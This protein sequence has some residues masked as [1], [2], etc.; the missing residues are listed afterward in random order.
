MGVGQPSVPERCLLEKEE[1]HGGGY[2]VHWYFNG[3]NL[4]WTLSRDG[5]IK[6]I[7]FRTQM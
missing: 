5:A 1:G 4:R 2:N 7:L 6:T 3:R